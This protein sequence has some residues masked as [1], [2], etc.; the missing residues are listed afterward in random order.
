MPGLDFETA[1]LLAALPYGGGVARQAAEVGYIIGAG[2]LL[3][4]LIQPVQFFILS[5]YRALPLGA[6]S[7]YLASY[8]VGFVPAL[9]GALVAPLTP[10]LTP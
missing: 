5:F 10:L 4:L 7:A 2:V 6:F 1:G 9:L 3:K 8:Y